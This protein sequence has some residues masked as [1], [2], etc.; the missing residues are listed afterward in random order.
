M[1]DL[2]HAERKQRPLYTGLLK[3]FPKALMEV[4]YCSWVATEKVLSSVGM[5]MNEHTVEAFTYCQ[6]KLLRKV[7]ALRAQK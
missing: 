3:Y 7:M 1:S 4:A 2:T 6:G 5:T